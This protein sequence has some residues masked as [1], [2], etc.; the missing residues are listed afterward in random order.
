MN[1]EDRRIQDNVGLALAELRECSDWRPIQDRWKLPS[2]SRKGNHAV[3]RTR[4]AGYA[5]APLLKRGG[6]LGSTCLPVPITQRDRK[7]D[8]RVPHPQPPPPRLSTPRETDLRTAT[9]ETPG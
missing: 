6:L 2:R 9:E 1:G 7:L 8:S 5:A 4:L 3:I